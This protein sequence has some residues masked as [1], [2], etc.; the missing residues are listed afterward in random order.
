MTTRE[1]IDA[2]T[3]AKSADAAADA[4]L[5]AAAEA[6]GNSAAADA[7]AAKALHD[8]LVANGPAAVISADTP[9]VVTVY[10]AS[11]PDSYTA[12]PVRVA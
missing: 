1:L 2:A 3:A 6:K 9:P 8:D 4:A 5:A 11:E 10:V 7:A 12:G